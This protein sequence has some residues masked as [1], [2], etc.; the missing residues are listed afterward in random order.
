MGKVLILQILLIVGSF[1]FSYAGIFLS[2]DIPVDTEYHSYEASDI[3]Y[4]EPSFFLFYLSGQTLGIPEGVNIEAFDFYGSDILFSVD[5]PLILDGKSF[6][7]KDI[8]LYEGSTFSKILNGAD[9]GIPEGAQ[10]DAATVLPD[11]KIIFSLDIPVKIGNLTF[12]PIDLIIYDGF[13]V[14]LYFNGIESGLPESANLD[15]VWV[16]PEGSM[17]F[18]LDIPTVIDGL[19]VTD[20]DF[21]EWNGSSFLLPFADISANLPQEADVD[22]L[23]VADWC[24]GDDNDDRDVDGSDLAAYIIESQG[25]VIETFAINF[26]RT[27]CP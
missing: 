21:I 7:E 4:H 6:T 17:L 14:D 18:S 22:A 13:S 25:L 20:K 1:S 24:H 15:G 9:V 19:S 12:K 23:A 27:N 11:G 10:I 3:A 8:I 26:G 16:N 5:V 2:T